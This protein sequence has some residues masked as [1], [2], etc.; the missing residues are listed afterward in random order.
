MEHILKLFLTWTNLNRR[1]SCQQN[2]LS[3]ECKHKSSL[4]QTIQ[5]NLFFVRFDFV[6]TF[7]L[8][9]VSVIVS[10]KSFRD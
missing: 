8:H 6:L 7:L 9:L 3:E 5:N 4:L 10:V 1:S 2:S